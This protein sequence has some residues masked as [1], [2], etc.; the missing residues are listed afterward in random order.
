M[1]PRLRGTVM[2]LAVLVALSRVYLGV[3]F[4]T[5][6]LAGAVLGLGIAVVTVAAARRVGAAPP[7]RTPF[8]RVPIAARMRAWRSSP[9]T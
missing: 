5:D 2:A 7:V 8:T 4:P 1:H 3:H 9:S 6:V